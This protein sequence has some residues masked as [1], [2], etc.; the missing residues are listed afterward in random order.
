MAERFAAEGYA[1]LAFDYR[2]FGE[3]G[4]EP[5]QL[6]SVKRQLEDWRA[7]I[8]YAQDARRRRRRTGSALWGSS[9]SGGHVMA[10]AAEDRSIEAAISQSPHTDGIKTLLALGPA[11]TARASP[12][13]R[14]RDLAAAA[15]GRER[16][17]DPDRRP[18]RLD[19]RR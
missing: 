3:S 7:A 2:Y 6:L 15:L 19:R 8:A 17:S 1:G 10:L 5:R 4:G 16:T 9:Y 14:L 11:R 12:S 13:P 18:A